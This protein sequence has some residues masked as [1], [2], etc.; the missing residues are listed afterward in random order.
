MQAACSKSKRTAVLCLLSALFVMGAPLSGVAQETA[1]TLESAPVVAESP[2]LSRPQAAPELLLHKPVF[3]ELQ[4]GAGGMSTPGQTRFAQ[5]SSC[6]QPN[7]NC[8]NPDNLPHGTGNT[9]AVVSDTNPYYQNGVFKAAENFTPSTTGSVTS[10]CWWGVY[11][12]FGVPCT[13]DSNCAAWPE[14]DCD[15]SAGVCDPP[16]NVPCAVDADCPLLPDCGSD[17]FCS[18]SPVGDCGPGSGDNFT[19]T[20]YTNFPGFPGIPGSV[21][22]G[23]FAVSPSS[24]PTGGFLASALGNLAVYSYSANHPAV[25]VMAGECYWI[26]IRNATSGNCVWLWN[27]APPADGVSIRDNDQPEDPDAGYDFGDIRTFDLAFC[28]NRALAPT[29]C[30]PTVSDVCTNAT[31]S[32]AVAHGGLGCENPECCAVVC[33][34]DPTCCEGSWDASCVALAAAAC[35]PACGVPGTGQCFTSNGSPYCDDYNCCS[36]V[37]AFDPFCCAISPQTQGLWDNFCADEADQLC[38]C[39]PGSEPANDACLNAVNI[40]LGDTFITNECATFSEPSHATCSDNFLLGL[41]LDV[42]YR[43]NSN[44]TGELVISTCDL[45]DSSWDTQIAVYQG[46]DCNDLSDP[47]LACNND[48]NSCFNSAHSRVA[49]NVET[50]KCYLIRVGSS[51]EGISGSGLLRLTSDVS[52]TC[53]LNGVIPPQ[54]QGEGE[55]CGL[56]VNGGCNYP[57]T[58]DCCFSNGSPGCASGACEAAVCTVN[59]DCCDVVWNTD[60]ANLAR[61]LCPDCPRPFTGLFCG[62]VIHGTAWAVG[63]TRDTD[64]YQLV[65]TEPLDV[66]L[67][68]EAEFAFQMGLVQTSPPGADSCAATTG[69]ISPFATGTFCSET[70]LPVALEPGVYWPFVATSAL[71]GVPCDT[72]GNNDYILRV[73]CSCDGDLNGNGLVNAADLAALLGAWGPNPGHPAD[74]NFNGVVN[75][76][77]LAVLL[78]AWGPCSEVLG[79]CC[80]AN[81]SGDCLTLT[82]PECNTAGGDFQGVSTDCSEC[83]LASCGLPASDDCCATNPSPGCND[84][85]CCRSICAVNPSCCADTWTADC[86]ALANSFCVQLCAEPPVNNECIDALPILDGNTVFDTTGATTD[87][88]AHEK[89]CQFDGQVYNDIWYDYTATCSGLLRVSTCDQASYDSDLAVYDGCDCANLM[90]LGCNDDTPG[91]LGSTSRVQVPADQGSC[92]KIRVGGFISNDFGAG[93]LSI[94]CNC[95]ADENCDD[96]DPCTADTC[97]LL[98]GDCVHTPACNDSNA[99]TVD[100]CTPGTGACTNTPINPAVA[101]NDAN[102]CTLD[103]CDPLIGCVNPPTCDD[104]DACTDDLCDLGGACTHQPIA[105]GTCDDLNPCTV[106][107]CNSLIGCVNPPLNCPP[108]QVCAGG[109]CVPSP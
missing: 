35:E 10:V 23:P 56:D 8:Q 32:C 44:I 98:T 26:E 72:A 28:I 94:T 77:D 47:P 90:L 25:S 48:D 88:P 5:G 1:A 71:N 78:G 12:N 93:T 17:N 13:I 20:Y 74:F 99:C 64:W 30:T 2:K 76:A 92:Y 91:C 42:W 109:V 36:L 69:L 86:A 51:F 81:P 87:G 105:P 34:L 101:C 11:G 14:R 84:D 16:S 65:I 79:A 67:T 24:S 38:T 55:I 61:D 75:A 106:D 39:A 96:A 70:P 66:S 46:C 104:G 37:C 33:A 50:G 49:V 58:N 4:G 19:V 73:T 31:G 43:Y 89:L 18:G 68:I 95:V 40:G 41:G 100:S 60:C 53:S 97:S 6:S 45:V 62:D 80:D 52:P 9:V 3:G 54:A 103:L 57:G 59:P 15:S 22:A 108:G 107:S 102:I 29:N 63:G 7:G 83:L 27:T 85:D 21:H 82:E